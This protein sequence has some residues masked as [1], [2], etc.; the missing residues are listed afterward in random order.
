MTNSYFGKLKQVIDRSASVQEL[1]EL[2]S[3]EN[4]DIRYHVAQNPSTPQSVLMKLASDKSWYVR[5]QVAKNPSTP[6]KVLAL[7]LLDLDIHD[8][9]I[10]ILLKR[11]R[12]NI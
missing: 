1:I 10:E 7:L 12:E 8:I 4:T 5:C 2:A 6:R 3:D 11:N 9:V